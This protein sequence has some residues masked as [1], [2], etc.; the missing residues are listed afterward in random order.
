VYPSRDIRATD[1]IERAPALLIDYFERRASHFT[2]NRV[3]RR[4]AAPGQWVRASTAHRRDALHRSRNQVH[5]ICSRA[6]L[7]N[8]QAAFT[9]SDPKHHQRSQEQTYFTGG[10]GS[11]VDVRAS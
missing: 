6:D 8:A 5:P 2:C 7:V 11:I 10:F 3:S 9:T 1:P 4:W